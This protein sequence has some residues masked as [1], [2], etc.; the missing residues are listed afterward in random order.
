MNEDLLTALM[1]DIDPV[2][3]LSDDAL[4]ELVSYNHLMKRVLSGIEQS[5]TEAVRNRTSIWHLASLRIGAVAAAVV[6]VASG[7]VALLGSSPT[8]VSGGFALGAV[9]SSWVEYSTRPSKAGDFGTATRSMATAL[10]SKGRISTVLRL[11][12]L[13]IAPAPPSTKP[14]V[15]ATQMAIELWATTSLQGQTEVAFGYG[16]ITLNVSQG[17]V[18]KFHSVPVWMAIATS[19]P[20]RTTSVCGAS[21]IASRPLTVV[22]SGYGLPNSEA[23]TGTPIAFTYQTKGMNSTTEPRLL[24]A[25]EQVS[26]PWVQDGR[27]TNGRLHMT[28]A[29]VPCG[30]L[31]GYSLTTNAIGTTLAVKGLIPVSTIGDYCT[32]S[33]ASNKVIPLRGANADVT[34]L[35][36]AQTGPIRAT[37]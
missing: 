10:V 17:G 34:T 11:D 24:P 21:A 23:T 33:A 9:H 4:D 7:A 12:G 18:P 2:R 31:N 19:K 8:A 36:H 20:C 16:D 15:S 1:T 30:A 5:A 14:R 29:P 6:L 35:L 27:V 28:A 37:K 13:T 26:V 25:I 3:D 32:E 22:V